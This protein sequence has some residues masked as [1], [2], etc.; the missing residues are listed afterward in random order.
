MIQEVEVVLNND[1]VTVVK[2]GDVFVQFP[3]IHRDAKT[4]YVKYKWGQY[5][6]VEDY[7]PPEEE[8][9]EN[10]DF[11]RVMNSYLS[12]HD[13]FLLTSD[14]ATADEFKGELELVYSENSSS[15]ETNNNGDSGENG[16]ESSQSEEEQ[17][18]DDEQDSGSTEN[19]T[20][21]ATAAGENATG[22]EEGE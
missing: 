21:N 15:T 6:I 20:D 19:N 17:S 14:I 10:D 2:F 22:E 13:I 7:T 18:L 16:G 5:S 12:K 3:S 11:E 9:V 1:V 4:I 8:P